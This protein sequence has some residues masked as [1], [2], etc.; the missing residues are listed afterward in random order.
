MDRIEDNVLYGEE[1][2]NVIGAAMAVHSELGFGFLEKVYQ[3]ALEKE[4]CI[5]G[6]PYKR[7]A[8]FPVYYKGE[9]LA[10][11]Y[12]TDFICFDKIIVELK[13]ASSLTADHK[14]QVIN[15][16]KITNMQLGILINFGERKLKYE[17]LILTKNSNS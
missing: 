11:K 1:S 12:V 5:R 13:A 3:E 10:C 7:E 6:I 14:A 16:L 8:K 15:Y 17:R 4:F 2:Y 9:L